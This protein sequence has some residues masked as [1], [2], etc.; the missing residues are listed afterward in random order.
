MHLLFWREWLRTQTSGQRDIYSHWI[1]SNDRAKPDG[2][3]VKIHKIANS[4]LRKKWNNFRVLVGPV[5]AVLL[6]ESPGDGTL[7]EAPQKHE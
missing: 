4:T 5:D 2:M 1:E 6:P 7:S 3:P